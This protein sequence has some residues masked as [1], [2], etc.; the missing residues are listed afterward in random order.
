MPNQFAL[1]NALHRALELVKVEWPGGP[2]FRSGETETNDFIV[3]IHPTHTGHSVSVTFKNVPPS[4]QWVIMTLVWRKLK[5]NVQFGR[6][7]YLPASAEHG[8]ATPQY[9]APFRGKGYL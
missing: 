2:E 1:A 9:A 4:L 5:R 8:T 7:V 6:F 3:K